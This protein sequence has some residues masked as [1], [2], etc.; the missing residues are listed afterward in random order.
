MLNVDPWPFDQARNCAVFTTRLVVERREPILHVTHDADDHGWQFI[1][2]SD[3]TRENHMIIAF[4]EAVELDPSV[5]EVADLPV[6]WHAVRES[7]KHPW[8]R[9]PHPEATQII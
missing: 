5:L 2:S 1:G 3:G 7:P 9:G 6:G 8:I 4:H